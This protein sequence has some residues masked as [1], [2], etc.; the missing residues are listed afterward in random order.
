MLPWPNG[1]RRRSPKAKDVGSTP[2]GNT[3]VV[4]STGVRACFINTRNRQMSGTGEFDPLAHYQI[5]ETMGPWPS[6]LGAGLLSRATRV[7][8]LPALPNLG[9]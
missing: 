3:R 4:G 6:G 8:F 1:L 9:S 5:Y 2:A 7:Q